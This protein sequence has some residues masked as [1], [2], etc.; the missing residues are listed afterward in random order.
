MFFR[1]GGALILLVMISLSGIAIEKHN[2]ALRRSI[3]HQ[4]F[5][6]EVLLEQHA[7]QRLKAHQFAAPRRLLNNRTIEPGLNL[8]PIPRQNKR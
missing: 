2:L 1:F 8:Q 3:S 6:Q 4:R 5:R 7:T